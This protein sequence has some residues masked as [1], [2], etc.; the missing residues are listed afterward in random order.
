MQQINFLNALPKPIKVQ[1][2]S[3]QLSLVVAGF[4][5]LLAIIS[6]IKL[7][8][9]L[10][11]KDTLAAA[12]FKQE[13]VIAETKKLQQQYPEIF[14]TEEL[15]EKVAGLTQEIEQK[16]SIVGRANRL[17]NAKAFSNYLT[18]LAYNTPNNLWLT[19]IYINQNQGQVLL[20]GKTNSAALIPAF[21]KNLSTAP[22]FSGD[23]FKEVSIND[24]K[25]TIVDFTIST[26]PD[27]SE[28]EPTE[29]LN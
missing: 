29:K 25:N 5:A 8:D 4:I 2:S 23:S 27:E 15:H 6:L 7:W 19:R 3:R 24:E 14:T 26:K 13:Q 9:N 1:F 17:S 12:Q 10:S 20:K 21:I 16:G 22:A 28:D 18:S 11:L